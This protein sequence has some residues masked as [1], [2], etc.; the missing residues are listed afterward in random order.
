LAINPAKIRISQNP[1]GGLSVSVTP[2]PRK[3][4]AL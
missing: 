3:R 4:I 1:V 2:P